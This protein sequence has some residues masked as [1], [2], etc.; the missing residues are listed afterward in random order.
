MARR[1]ERWEPMPAARAERLQ[2]ALIRTFGRNVRKF[3]RQA[4]LIA[5][6]SLC[7]LPGW[8]SNECYAFAQDCDR[9]RQPLTRQEVEELFRREGRVAQSR[10]HPSDLGQ[11]YRGSQRQHM[12]DEFIRVLCLDIELRKNRRREI[13]QVHRHDYIGLPDDCRRQNVAII[14]IRQGLRWP[15]KTG[16]VAKKSLRL[17][18]AGWPEVRLVEYSEEAQS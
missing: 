15:P 18:A 2:R 16:Q 4:K 9:L 7:S 12:S 5:L 17:G 8:R 13:L 3:R 1:I 11:C 6:S 14:G 10:A